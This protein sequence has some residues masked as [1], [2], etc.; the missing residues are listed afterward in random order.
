[1]KKLLFVLSIKPL[2][3]FRWKENGEITT[4]SNCIG[5]D[6]VGSVRS[7]SKTESKTMTFNG[8]DVMDHAFFCN[9]PGIRSKKGHFLW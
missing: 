1:M 7:W 6:K 2:V 3:L 9:D 4:G 8:I 5:V